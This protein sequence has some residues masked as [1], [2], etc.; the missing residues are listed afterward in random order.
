A[1]GAELVHR[2]RALQVLE[3]R[4]D[5]AF[6]DRLAGAEDAGHLHVD[7]AEPELVPHRQ[8]LARG[9]RT[10]DQRRVAL[11]AELLGVS[12]EHADRSRREEPARWRALEG[13]EIEARAAVAEIDLH[14]QH[15]RDA[16]DAGDALAVPLGEI[17]GLRAVAVLAIDDERARRLRPRQRRIET[18]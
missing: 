11:A 13:H 2:S 7:V 12:L 17:R 9:E 5:H 3:V 15:R 1:H 14:R 8:M 6:L 4:E 10:A 18:A 16:A